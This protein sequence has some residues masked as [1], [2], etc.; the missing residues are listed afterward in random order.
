MDKLRMLVLLQIR[1]AG[2]S[3]CNSSSVVLR[4]RELWLEETS[5]CAMATQSY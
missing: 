4:K 1:E 3:K 2:I 5:S